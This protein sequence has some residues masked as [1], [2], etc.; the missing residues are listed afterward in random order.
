LISPLSILIFKA[1]ADTHTPPSPGKEEL[2]MQKMWEIN[3]KKL[4]KTC[5][6][7][8]IIHISLPAV[9]AVL[10]LGLDVKDILHVQLEGLATTSPYHTRPLV[11]LEPSSGYR[12]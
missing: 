11:H 4:R 10:I 6:H 5:T 2:L 8:N 9:F 3:K 1:A 12:K 7:E